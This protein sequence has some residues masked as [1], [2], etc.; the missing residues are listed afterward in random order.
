[1]A[2]RRWI[3][4]G[5]LICVCVAPASA[6]RGDRQP[7][8]VIPAR[9]TVVQFAFDVARLRPVHLV[10]YDTE[11]KAGTLLLYVWDGGARKWLS[12]SLDEYGSGGIFRTRP[13][14]VILVGSDRELPAGLAE[15][16]EQGAAVDR[17][18]SM[19]VVDMVNGLNAVM[20]FD[21]QEWRYL[22]KRYDLQLEDRNAERR[23][24]GRY[25]PPGGRKA[26]PEMPV[27]RPDEIVMPAPIDLPV[28]AEV[29][30]EE[31][32]LIG[33]QA[34]AEMAPEEKGASAAEPPV[35]REKGAPE[36]EADT[37]PEDK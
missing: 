9:Y 7:L 25:G 1:M 26:E 32:E 27:P 20:G 12:T 8:L 16:S 18:P 4:T 36:T 37:A 34:E 23:R 22:A 31:P 19:K 30:G 10:A 3:L 14:R 21:A 13:S 33:V 28:P 11:G 24:Y 5:V 2:F 6:A 35:S 15:A 17:I 29:V